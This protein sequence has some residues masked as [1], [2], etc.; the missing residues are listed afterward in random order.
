MVTTDLL[1]YL[2]Q[3]LLDARSAKDQ[4]TL[5][6]LSKTFRIL[7]EAIWSVEESSVFAAFLEDMA[8][9]VGD[10]LMGVEWRSEIPSI[11]DIQGKNR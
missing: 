1:L 10:S 4:K 11:E 2:R 8:H 9:A 3:R 6:E 5:D 7:Q